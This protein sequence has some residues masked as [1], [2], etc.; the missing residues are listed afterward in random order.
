MGAGYHGGFGSTKG[1]SK[2]DKNRDHKSQRKH[3]TREQLIDFI[4]GK[5]TISSAIADKILKGMIKISVLGD[6]LFE[7]AL[8]V[9]S[10]VVGLAIDN[11]IYIRASSST[12]Y[13]DI[14][15]E[16]THA[17]D[18][19]Q[20]LPYEK[21]SSRDGEIRAYIAEHQFQKVSGLIVQFTNEDEIR[22]HVWLNYKLRGKK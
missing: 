15:H 19:L 17:M 9:S 10:E 16:G 5:T 4:N 13:S 12:I 18:Y 1:S 14:V 2:K 11:K 20:G 21:I 6:E 22:V 8:G 7:R 3:Y